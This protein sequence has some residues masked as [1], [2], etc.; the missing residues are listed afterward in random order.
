MEFDLIL[1]AIWI[2]GKRIIQQGTNGI[3]RVED[4]VLATCGLSLGGMVPLHLSARERSH[5]QGGRIRGWWNTGRKLEV[6]E[7]IDWST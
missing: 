3:S 6:L 4:N 7:P 1:H 5:G 2:A